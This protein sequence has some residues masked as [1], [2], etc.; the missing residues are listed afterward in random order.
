MYFS[1]FLNALR[2]TFYL[3]ISDSFTARLLFVHTLLQVEY[4]KMYTRII[5][6]L[7]F[8]QARAKIVSLDE[9]TVISRCCANSSYI[10][11][12]RYYNTKD[13]VFLDHIQE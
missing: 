4:N 1:L 10:I 11:V 9:C 12:T 2:E 6:I 3:Y 5:Y 13:K 7:H 8:P